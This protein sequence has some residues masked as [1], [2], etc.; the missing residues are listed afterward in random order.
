MTLQELSRH[1]KL[2]ERLDRDLELLKSLEAAEWPRD[3]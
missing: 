1:F 2:R 3:T